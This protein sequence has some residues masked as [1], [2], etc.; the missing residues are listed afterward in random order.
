M[1]VSCCA[2]PLVVAR[3]A[4]ARPADRGPGEAV[5]RHRMSRT[6]TTRT[7]R[8]VDVV[9]RLG[10]LVTLAALLV[11]AGVAGGLADGVTPQHDST[12]T[13]TFG[14]AGH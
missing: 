6:A 3:P 4:V 11:L 2:P 1:T 10:T 5:G 7:G 14:G 9:A 12:V 8:V 13:A